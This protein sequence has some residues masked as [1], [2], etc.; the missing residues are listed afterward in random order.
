MDGLNFTL[1]YNP[2]AGNA[3]NP[4]ETGYGF[5]YTGVEGLSLS[6]A[7]TDEESGAT[8]TSGDATVYKVSYAYGP[9]TAT[10]SDSEMDVSAA[11]NAAGGDSQSYALSYTVSDELSITYGSETHSIDSTAVDMEIEGFSASYT[12]G[13]MTITAKMQSMD[14]G[15]FATGANNDIDYWSLNASFAF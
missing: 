15:N 1:S 12:S 2:Q 9:V 8:A 11:A 5:N 3:T 10:Y 7:T 13:G 4:S 14:D 6:Y